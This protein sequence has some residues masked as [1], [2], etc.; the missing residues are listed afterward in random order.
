[1]NKRRQ[2]TG[3]LWDLCS[4]LVTVLAPLV[5]VTLLI[6]VL[7]QGGRRFATLTALDQWLNS[8]IALGIQGYTW[9]YFVTML[10]CGFLLSTRQRLGEREHSHTEE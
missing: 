5:L 6:T 4:L 10:A 3:C 9:V 1:M 8:D 7:M 2:Q